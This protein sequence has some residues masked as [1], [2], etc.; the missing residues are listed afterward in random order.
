MDAAAAAEDGG[1]K[2]FAAAAIER[3]DHEF[4]DAAIGFEVAVDEGGG[5]FLR[6]AKAFR[7]AEGALGI[8]ET[9]YEVLRSGFR[10][11]HR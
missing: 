10:G 1:D 8:G 7:K 4:G 11:T 6:D 3:V 5:F 9:E 2:A